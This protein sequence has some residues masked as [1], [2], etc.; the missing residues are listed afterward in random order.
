M[1]FRSKH[2][3]L[4]VYNLLPRVIIGRL[5]PSALFKYFAEHGRFAPFWAWSR[6]ATEESLIP[7][8]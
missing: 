5:P 8:H 2:I 4:I 1:G 3:T 6:F 7:P